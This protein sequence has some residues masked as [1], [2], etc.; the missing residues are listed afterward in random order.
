MQTYDANNHLVSTFDPGQ[1]IFDLK[2]VPLSNGNYALGWDT[3]GGGALS[4]RT[5]HVELFNAA[6]TSLA[7]PVTID[8]PG[9]NDTLSNLAALPGGGFL[10]LQVAAGVQFYAR[11]FSANGTPDPQPVAVGTST[12]LRNPTILPDGEIVLIQTVNNN[13]VH[14]QRYDA[15]GNTIGSEIVPVS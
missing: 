2:I 11:S 5:T 3:G 7:G 13:E 15:H 12:Q 10:T 14:V 8:V 1:R 6:G 4:E 9:T